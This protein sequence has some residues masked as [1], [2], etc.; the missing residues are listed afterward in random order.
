VDSSSR[1]KNFLKTRTR[2]I[3]LRF[4][5]YGKNWL[6]KLNKN[7]I[8]KNQQYQLE[9]DKKL[10]FSLSK[11]R[12]PNLRQLKHINKYYTKR[13]TLVVRSC[14]LVILVCSIFL[15]T[16]FYINHLETVPAVGGEYVE[17][18]IGTP[19]YINPLYSIASDIDSDLTGL[20]YSSLFKRNESGQLVE[21]LASQYEVSSDSKSYTI[22][23]KDGV[24]FHNGSILTVDDI[25]FTFNAIKDVQYKSPLRAS[26]SGVE[27][28]RVDDSTIKF[29]LSEPYAAFLDLLTFGILPSELWQHITPTAASL[30]ELNLKPIG[31]GPYKFKSLVKDK[32]G[33]LK[34]YNLVSFEDYFGGQAYIEELIFK[35][36]ANYIEMISALN[37]NLIDG[38]SY[39]PD[40]YKKE[41][42]A[43]DSLNLY[44]LNLPQLTAIFFNLKSDSVV[45]DLNVRQAL[46]YALNREQMVSD[47]I[48]EDGNVIDGPILPDSFAYFS[49]VKKYHYEPETAEKLFD[50]AGWKKIE[51][52]SEEIIAAEGELSSEDEK[53]KLAAENKIAMGAGQWRIKD[54]QY[55]VIELTTVETVD[56][57]ALAEAIA[58]AWEGIGVKTQIN[59][60]SA[61]KIQNEVIRQRKYSI[62]LYGEIVG[63]DPDPYAFWHSS[64][65]EQGGLNISN[66]VSKEVDQL[67][68]DA[69]LTSDIEVRKEKYKE[70]Q[71]IIADDLPAIFIY[72]PVYTYAQGKKIKGFAV[73][74][75]SL[76]RDRFSNINNWYIDTGKELVW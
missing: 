7:E 73:A 62:L 5:W 28:E 2:E 34:S 52:S 19:K 45:K 13:E 72:N 60:V 65:S 32:S 4:C 3:W 39:L 20:I 70:F 17:G 35:S 71:K 48:G 9:L 26:F 16:R 38:I 18:V 59:L 53:I 67:L 21:D 57:I 43:Q 15:G 56:Y 42:A 55:L 49:D 10:V 47:L 1:R 44:K 29:V 76:P 25:L 46:S 64:Q 12:V 30:A 23:I 66:Y 68:E 40:E 37:S 51:I 54:G 31:S 69:R 22:K 75:I 50:D 11:K 61:G 58:Q 74:N 14:F 63:L 6:A 33:N 36:F 27:I 8:F 24:K 41:I